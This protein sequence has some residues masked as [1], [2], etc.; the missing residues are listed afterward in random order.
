M[1]LN[2]LVFVLRL[3]FLDINAYN[4]RKGFD[5]ARQDVFIRFLTEQGLLPAPITRFFSAHPE[6]KPDMHCVADILYNRDNFNPL[7]YNMP[8]DFTK[9]LVARPFAMDAA[10]SNWL[11]SISTIL[12]ILRVKEIIKGVQ[13]PD[14]QIEWALVTFI[15]SCPFVLANI[16]E[17]YITQIKKQHIGT[18]EQLGP[19][20]Q[21]K[22][23]IKRFRT[24]I[25]AQQH[26]TPATITLYVY[27]LNQ[28]AGKI[29]ENLWELEDAESVPEINK[30]S[31]IL[32]EK[33]PPYY[34]AALEQ[35]R[36]FLRETK[37]NQYNQGTLSLKTNLC[38][39][40]APRQRG[41]TKG[42]DANIVAFCFSCGYETLYPNM[43]QA[44]AIRSAAKELGIKPQ[45][46]Q[47][48]KS[49]F[50]YYILDNSRNGWHCPSKSLEAIH[51]K[52]LD[53]YL[54]YKDGG[55]YK[56]DNEKLAP[57]YEKARKILKL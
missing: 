4:I 50:D 38:P 10:L 6:I 28:I 35:Y 55:Y 17:N 47:N 42:N 3:D 36:V 52:I 1:I 33:I 31:E 32:G 54:T 56:G 26:L 45:T 39:V 37:G 40:R 13:I 15:E 24:Y 5:M 8:Q 21:K 12:D 23:A 49:Y 51:R 57:A 22:A 48:M 20:S 53:Q 18:V 29:C 34:N 44:D 25:K 11:Q 46:L 41:S 14:E 2:M 27:A 19:L 9:I 43:K 7:A 30:V 16:K